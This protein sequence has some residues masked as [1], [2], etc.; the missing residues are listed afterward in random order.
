MLMNYFKSANPKQSISSNT[1]NI[2]H[3]KSNPTTP[4]SMNSLPKRLLPEKG[5][6]RPRQSQWN[7]SAEQTNRNRKIINGYLRR[8][9]NCIGK[10]VSLN[11]SG[12]CY[13]QYRKFFITIEVPKDNAGF[14]FLHTMVSKLEPHDNYVAAMRE[15]MRL[16]YMQQGTRGACL[17]LEGD[18]MNLCFSAPVSGLGRDDFVNCLDD[19]METTVEMNERIDYAKRT[20]QLA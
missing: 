1:K 20:Q 4:C 9:G 18:E 19:F 14:F 12:I 16:N 10:E 8:V 2:R 7:G 15:A 11:S 6:N 13:Y 3:S 17:G 5:C